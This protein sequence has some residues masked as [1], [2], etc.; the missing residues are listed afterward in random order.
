MQQKGLLTAYQNVFHKQ[1]EDGIIERINVDPKD[2]EKFVWIPHRPVFK[3]E[4]NVTTKIRPVFNCS[5]KTNKAP[6]LN[7][8][9]YGGINLMGDI[10][11]LSLYFR[12]NDLVM[13]SDIKQ[14]FLQIMLA[15]EEDKS[16]FCFFMREG[17]E[18]IAYRYKTI[19]FGSNASPFILNYVIKHHANQ[20][21]NDEFTRILKSNFYVDNLIVTGNS[22]RFLERVYLESV[23]RM[24]QGGFCLRSWNSNNP[25]LQN[26]MSKNDDLVSHGNNYEKVLGLKYSLE[27]DSIQLADSSLDPSVDTKRGILSQISKVFDPLGLLLPVTTKGRLLMRELWGLKLDWDEVVSDQIQKEWRKHCAD[28]SLLS[29]VSLPRSCVN[30]DTTNSLC[31]FCDASKSCY[32]FAVYNVCNGKSQLLF[33]KS[34][35]A[36]VKPKTLPMLEFLGV[37]LAMKCL[38]LVLESFTA[39]K[40]QNVTITVD[41]Q[42]VLQWLLADS[43]ST[44]SIFTRNRIKDIG[45]F[46]EN[47]R[48]RYGVSLRFKYVRSEDKPCGLINRGL[49][50]AEFE[51]NLEFWL[52]GPVWLP[53]YDSSWPE[54]SLRCLSAASKLQ[55]QPGKATASFN[56]EAG[57]LH[58]RTLID[59][60]KFSDFNKLAMFSRL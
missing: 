43:V 35:V 21:A 55:T 15:K 34:R 48:D 4:V 23:K 18:L 40:F 45:M 54:S 49:S 41:S 59:F 60:E 47:L 12:S 6:S 28:L 57:P 30:E 26:L 32:G 1:L 10:V 20:L 8:A 46:K 14:A 5:L 44:K 31:I 2:F 16:K 36:P 39:V 22:P 19:I 52:N 13:L 53:T 27:N 17:D 7:E 37:Y 42:I 24:S 50:H 51:K 11:K 9:A 3:G 25:E 29:N 38:P 56:I 58:I 33:A